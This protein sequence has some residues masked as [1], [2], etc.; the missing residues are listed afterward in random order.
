MDAAVGH[1]A[2]FVQGIQ[3]G[4]F[5]PEPPAAGCPYYCSARL[6]WN[7]PRNPPTMR[8]RAAI[9]TLPMTL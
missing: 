3:S 4:E 6:F 5:A 7:S 2:A 9:T 1:A 8:L